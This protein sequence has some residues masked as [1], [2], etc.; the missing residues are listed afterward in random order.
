MVNLAT[1]S[2]LASLECSKANPPLDIIDEARKALSEGREPPLPLLTLPREMADHPEVREIQHQFGLTPKGPDGSSAIPAHLRTSSTQVE[3]STP[4]KWMTFA[5]AEE[6]V[7]EANRAWSNSQASDEG[8]AL[9]QEVQFKK[10][11]KER[12]TGMSLLPHTSCL[13]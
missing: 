1:L 2:A 5:E 3:P 4:P 6:K 11:K 12:P 10:N 13:R 9:G 8:A 7:K